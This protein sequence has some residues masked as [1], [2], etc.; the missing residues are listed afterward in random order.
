MTVRDF[1]ILAFLRI[2]IEVSFHAAAKH[3]EFGVA[4]C[5]KRSQYS[6]ASLGSGLN[7]DTA[8]PRG[9][10]INGALETVARKLVQPGRLGP[11]DPHA[12]RRHVQKI[13]TSKSTCTFRIG[14]RRA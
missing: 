6:L 7:E 13:R 1:R 12:F 4:A 9:S 2:K 14:E 5:P 8:P 3:T 11:L 10:R